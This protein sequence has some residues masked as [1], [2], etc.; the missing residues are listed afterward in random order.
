MA[1]LFQKLADMIVGGGLKTYDAMVD[2][3]ELP[4]NQRIYLETVLDKNIS[5]ITEKNLTTKELETISKLIQTKGGQQGAIKY[6]DYPVPKEG[7]SA[8]ARPLS[9]DKFPYENIKTTLGQFTY[10][11]NPKTKEY[12]VSDVY[13]FNAN[14]LTG[15]QSSGDYIGKFF[16]SPY[17]LARA[18]GQN[19]APEGF[20][21]KVNIKV[22]GLLK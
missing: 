13:D 17:V 3:K 4:S 10:K 9:G 14:P 5:P 11:Y 12:E 22:P 18:Y 15:N 1:D 2:R 21:R 16:L 6:K 8:I 7:E 19:V 20:G